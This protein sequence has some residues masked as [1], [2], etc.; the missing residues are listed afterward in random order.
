[1]TTII[2]TVSL[3]LMQIYSLTPCIRGRY[4]VIYYGEIITI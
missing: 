2:I 1:M 4:L 3:Q